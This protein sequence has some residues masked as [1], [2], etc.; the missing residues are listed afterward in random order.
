MFATRTG[1]DFVKVL[2]VGVGDENLSEPFACHKVHYVTDA[3]GVKFV[4]DVVK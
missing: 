2:A 1:D 3:V 4:K